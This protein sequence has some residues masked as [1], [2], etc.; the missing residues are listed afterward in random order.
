MH[1]SFAVSIY[2]QTEWAGSALNFEAL[3]AK[4][5]KLMDADKQAQIQAHVQALAALLYAE[6]DPEQLKTLEG[7]EAAQV[8]KHRS[9]YL[10]GQFSS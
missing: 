2:A 10:N 1:L 3:I 7:I 4:G 9:A 8:L 5:K 6:T